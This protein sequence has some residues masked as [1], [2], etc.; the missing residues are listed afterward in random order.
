MARKVKK[1]MNEVLLHII[2]G[3][4][5]VMKSQNHVAP[6][7]YPPPV[8]PVSQPQQNNDQL[9]MMMKMLMEERSKP[10]VVETIIREVPQEEKSKLQTVDIGSTNVNV[11]TIIG[12]RKKEKE[13]ESKLINGKKESDLI[14]EKYWNEVTN[15]GYDTSADKAKAETKTSDTGI[16]ETPVPPVQPPKPNSVKPKNNSYSGKGK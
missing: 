5:E 4:M 1:S 14:L 10:S 6:A 3:L 8:Q 2:D 15:S 11:N 7:Y 13:E 12:G 16:S 9:M